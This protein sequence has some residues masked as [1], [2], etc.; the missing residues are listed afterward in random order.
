M[1][2]GLRSSWSLAVCSLFALT[3]ACGDDGGGDD[4]S[5]RADAAAN[6]DASSVPDATTAEPDAMPADISCLGNPPPT[7]APAT[8]TLSGSVFSIDIGGQA[9]V[10]GAIVQLRRSSTDRN[11]DSNAPDGTPADG[12]FSLMGKTRGNALEA[13]LRST[14][15]G[16][17][18]TRVYPPLPIFVDVPMVPVPMFNPIVV[19][20]LSP[21][22]EADKGIVLIL[23]VDCAG[24]PVQGAT[25]MSTPEAGGIIYTDDMGVPDQSATSTSAAGL[26]ILVNVPAGTVTVNATAMGETLLAHDV[27]SVPDEVTTTVVLPGAPLL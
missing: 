25:V 12:S 7:D 24:Q 2:F 15:E 17:V 8:V 19:N 1:R 14:A 27:A 11:L 5:D 6:I 26:G 3:A 18:T 16:L 22:Q 9:P 4:S 20:F 13:Y 23:V 10:E 21:D